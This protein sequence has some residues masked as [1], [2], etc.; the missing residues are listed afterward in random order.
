MRCYLLR[1]A[2]PGADLGATIS[3]QAKLDLLS[4]IQAGEGASVC[5]SKTQLLRPVFNRNT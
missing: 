1:S 3:F 5:T 4:H 2:C